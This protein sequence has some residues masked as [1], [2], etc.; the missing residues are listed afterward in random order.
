MDFGIA[1]HLVGEIAVV[2]VSGWIE[3]GSA[4]QMRDTLIGVIDEGHV[5]VVIDLSEVVFLDST[6][7]GVIIGLLHRLRT[8]NGSL[9]LAGATDRVYKVFRTTQLTKVL[10]ITETVADAIAAVNSG[11][12][13]AQAP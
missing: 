11:A 13:G 5:H 1:H 8:H 2:Q 12:A 3:I 7:L 6:G 9:A 10:T 4:P